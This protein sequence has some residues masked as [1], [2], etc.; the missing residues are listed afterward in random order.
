MCELPYLPA[1]LQRSYEKALGTSFELAKASL[2][3]DSFAPS[4]ETTWPKRVI[5][6]TFVKV[7]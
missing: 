6:S 5:G 7:G 1:H 2:T 3:F 4:L